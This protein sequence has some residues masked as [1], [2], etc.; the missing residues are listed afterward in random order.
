MDALLAYSDDDDDGGGSTP[1]STLQQPQLVAS[2]LRPLP[3]KTS[4][5]VVFKLP[6]MRG[7]D[8]DADESDLVPPPPRQPEDAGAKRPRDGDR[9]SAF[10]SSL[11]APKNASAKPSTTLA[12]AA[13]TVAPATTAAAPYDTAAD[14]EFEVDAAAYSDG[15]DGSDG[16][17]NEGAPP[18]SASAALLAHADDDGPALGPSF[19]PPD[20][21][22][23]AYPEVADDEQLQHHALDYSNPMFDQSVPVEGAVMLP[24]FTPHPRRRWLQPPCLRVQ[25]RCLRISGASCRRACSS[26]TSKRAKP[27]SSCA[28]RLHVHRISV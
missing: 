19:P 10:L 6:S 4:G 24:C 27:L 11:P 14:N 28:A 23:N 5:V 12:C 2:Q 25:C 26:S 1:A 21:Y 16:N 9:K 22:A 18:P 17:S 13:A 3:A 7:A 8:A 15:S 20:Y